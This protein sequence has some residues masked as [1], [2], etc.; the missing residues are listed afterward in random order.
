MSSPIKGGRYPVLQRRL[1]G[2]PPRWL[3]FLPSRELQRLF[4]RPLFVACRPLLA[5]P[6][7]A[8]ANSCKH[9]QLLALSL[10]LSLTR[11][12]CLPVNTKLTPLS[13]L[14]ST[15]SSS[16]T[17]QHFELKSIGTPTLS[18][19]WTTDDVNKLI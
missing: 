16:Q 9:R 19:T 5:N 3:A 4:R 10:Y 15:E 18:T 12:Y 7:P 14:V 2:A 11:D 8:G 6:T 1:R 13:T 17:H